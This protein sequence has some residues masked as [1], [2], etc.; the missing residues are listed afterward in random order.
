[1]VK[2]DKI[3]KIEESEEENKEE[4]T[5]KK[6]IKLILN[7]N[8]KIS[9]LKLEDPQ[10]KLITKYSILNENSSSQNTPGKNT[11][12][13]EDFSSEKISEELP[14]SPKNLKIR[15]NLKKKKKIKKKKKN[16]TKAEKLSL[17]LKNINLPQNNDKYAKFLDLENREKLRTRKKPE[18]IS[19]RSCICKST[20]CL[21][22]QCSCFKVLNFCSS[23][24]NC[25]NCQNSSKN[26]ILRQNSIKNLLAV[27]K[28]AFLDK[29]FLEV[30]IGREKILI[31]GCNCKKKYCG[32]NNCFCR[33]GGNKCSSICKCV[34]CKND[35]I[36][37][38]ENGEG[39]FGVK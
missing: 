5:K 13:I 17:E 8:G 6:S 33:K 26:E 23:S 3:S 22:L 24:C 38:E 12:I 30:G 9:I 37:L 4:D 39:N 32:D 34:G 19:Q 21:S 31:D 7:K 28:K 25:S 36:V 1:M 2:K 16:L 14:A 20:N 15:N 35:K 11:E 10:K 29:R 18:F 27:N